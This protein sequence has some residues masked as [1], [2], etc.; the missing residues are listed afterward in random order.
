MN[1]YYDDNGG[2]TGA[3]SFDVSDDSNSGA[4]SFDT[5]N[6]DSGSFDV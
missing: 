3:D 5:G 1:N 2:N 4:D 6:D